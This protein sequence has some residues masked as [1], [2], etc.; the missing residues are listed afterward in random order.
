MCCLRKRSWREG[1]RQ[2][3]RGVVSHLQDQMGSKSDSHFVQRK[4][5][6]DKK[7]SFLSHVWMCTSCNNVRVLWLHF[8]PNLIIPKFVQPV[9]SDSG[10]LFS[11][12]VLTSNSCFPCVIHCR[13]INV[14]TWPIFKYNALFPKK[15]ISSRNSWLFRIAQLSHL[16]SYYTDSQKWQN[17]HILYLSNSIITSVK[18]NCKCKSVF[19]VINATRYWGTLK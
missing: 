13:S 12:L 6:Q 19:L 9:F 17:I 10:G 1:G 11:S 18:E 3:S 8:H 14:L 5:K 15:F 2:K 7:L 16:L 4:K